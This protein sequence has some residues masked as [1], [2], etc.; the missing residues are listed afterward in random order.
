MTTRWQERFMR[1]SD[2]DTDRRLA[3][4]ESRM[5]KAEKNVEQLDG[6]MTC[7]FWAGFGGVF[8]YGLYRLICG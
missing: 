3:S 1:P 6:C 7:V 5:T 2:T 4:L 8:A